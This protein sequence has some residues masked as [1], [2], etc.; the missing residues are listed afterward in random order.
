[1]T[2]TPSI[3]V[4]CDERTGNVNQCLGVS[5][6]LKWPYE[7]IDLAYG[8]LAKLPNQLLG[9][10]LLGLTASSKSRL[11]EPWPDLVIAA[12]RRL[13]PVACHIKQRSGGKTRLVHIMD[14]GAFHKEFD[15]IFIPR[16]DDKADL[17]PNERW[18]TGAPHGITP[19]SLMAAQ[20][21][22]QEVFK[23]LPSPKVAL[24][25]GGATKNREFSNAMARELGRKVNACVSEMG[26][27]LLVTTSRRTGAAAPSLMSEMT[28]PAFTYQWGDEGENPY[29]GFLACADF[30]IVTGDSISM[31]SECC[32]TRKP[33]YIYGPE[34]MV[35]PK[36]ARFHKTLYD[37]GYAKAFEG[38]LEAF[39]PPTLNST[40]MMAEEIKRLFKGG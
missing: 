32:A 2:E 33:V 15:L 35:S 40:D 11:H 13:A 4:L 28:V 7:R 34:V 19:Q 17:A 37:G 1:M 9:K 24:I 30:L 31:C 16:H 18:V 10:S 12:G 26:G 14:P 39:S 6:A 25:V 38:T 3:W 36:H 23:A 27:A 21:H 8:F 20:G 29:R 22:W 5:D